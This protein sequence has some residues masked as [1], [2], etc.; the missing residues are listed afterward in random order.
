MDQRFNDSVLG[1]Q[2][3]D[4]KQRFL[5][6]YGFPPE[7]IFVSAQ[8]ERLLHKVFKAYRK[9]VILVAEEADIEG[10]QVMRMGRH[11]FRYEFIL[12]TVR[13]QQ[14][15]ILHVD[16]TEHLGEAV[17]RRS[18]PPVNLSSDAL[19]DDDDDDESTKT[20]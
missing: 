3:R 17:N 2:I 6:Q 19:G 10:M 14:R 5:A 9:S 1:I 12:S 20:N 4:S 15:H 16:L 18:E 13:N 11:S 7:Q 8:L